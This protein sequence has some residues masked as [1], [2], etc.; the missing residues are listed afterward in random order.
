MRSDQNLGYTE[1]HHVIPKAFG[2]SNEKSNIVVLTGREHYI[3]HRLL[4]RM[5]KNQKTKKS[6]AWA[7]HLMIHSV[8]LFQ[9]RY[10]PKSRAFESIR[11][12]FAAIRKAEPYVRT[13]E[14]QDKIN[15]ANTKRLKG[16]KFSDEVKAKM[17]ASKTGVRNNMFNKTHTAE[18]IQKIR[19]KVKGKPISFYG[20]VYSK[21]VDAEK[22]TGIKARKIKEL[23]IKNSADVFFL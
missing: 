12:E 5:V 15:A 7:L 21:M 1:K 3:C 11:R 9:D 4:V 2:G 16:T 13:K 6:M 17:S 18:A 22:A 23:S 8:N 20:T 14:H 10:L 19:D